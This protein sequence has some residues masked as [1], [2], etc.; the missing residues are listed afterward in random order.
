MLVASGHEVVRGDDPVGTEDGPASR[1]RRHPSRRRRARPPRGGGRG[2]QRQARCGPPGT[3]G[4]Y[5]LTG[6]RVSQYA[7]TDAAWFLSAGGGDE[8][9]WLRTRGRTWEGP[10]CLPGCRA[11]AG[12][13]GRAVRRGHVGQA[14][15]LSA[16]GGGG[17][18]GAALGVLRDG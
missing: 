15:R 6:N 11:R 9:R 12:A 8:R 18:T 4:P 16:T 2:G 10:C 7:P 14:L 17:G 5:V 1:A 3:A 13:A